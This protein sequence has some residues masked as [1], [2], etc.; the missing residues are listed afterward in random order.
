MDLPQD[1]D[2]VTAPM[3][4]RG[5]DWEHAEWDHAIEQSAQKIVALQQ[6]YGPRSIAVYLGNPAAHSYTALLAAQALNLA[7]GGAQRYSATSVDQLPHMLAALEMFGHQLMMPVPDI[8]RTEYFL[9]LGANP[10]ASNGSLM[11]AGAITKR[12]DALTARGAKLVVV[13]PRKTETAERATEH[14]AIRPGGDSYFLLAILHVLFAEKLTNLRALAPYVDQVEV[15][16]ALVHSWPPA[17]VAERTG[18]SADTITRVAREFARADRA[19][20]YGRVGLCTQE[21]GGLAAWLVNAVNIV[22]G[23]LDRAGGMMFTDPA[24]DLLPIAAALGQKGHFAKFRS[25]VRGLPEFGGELPA[26]T[27][28]EEIDTPGDGQ[29]RALITIAGNPVLSVPDGRRLESALKT[30]DFMLSVDIYCN[31][32]TGHAHVILP[33]TTGLERVHYDVALYNFS[34]RNTARFASPAISAPPGTRSDWDVLFSLTRAIYRARGTLKDRAME[35][36]VTATQRL[37]PEHALDALLRT[38]PYGTTR[39]GTLSLKALKASKHG[40]DLGPLKS[41]LPRGL[42]TKNKRVQLAPSLFLQDI[43]RL[44]SVLAHRV[45]EPSKLVLIGRRHVRSNN[46]W[47]HNSLRLV[48]GPDRCTLMMHPSDATNRGVSQGDVVRLS[49]SRGSVQASVELTDTLA[50]GVVSLP[51][52]YGHHRDA[53]QL[54]VARAHAGVSINDVTDTSFIDGLT[55]TAALNGVSVTIEKV[56]AT[57]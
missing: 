22:T 16:E 9:M 25:R 36:A 42:W 17:R 4:R 38:G 26:V 53:A 12:M 55:G 44:Q 13:D 47:M 29:I 32:T 30:L 37:G 48:K 19:V 24:V 1:P 10:V 28:A 8:D 27:L 23:N 2:R 33:T 7:L 49:S 5:H 14:L 35:A 56:P 31:E 57:E 40:I 21:F 46:S 15:L 20:C 11:T 34:V 39:G 6:K 54:N 43:Q 52:G 45:H 41:K 51:H 50:Q 3:M 18:L